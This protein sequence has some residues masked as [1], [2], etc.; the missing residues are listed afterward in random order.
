MNKL[1]SLCQTTN[2]L[3]TR[4]YLKKGRYSNDDGSTGYSGYNK[5]RGEGQLE[6][7][8]LD[9]YEITGFYYAET[10][11]TKSKV[12]Y[13]TFA[14]EPPWS[15]VIATRLDNN[16]TSTAT[17]GSKNT[18]SFTFDVTFFI[19]GCYDEDSYEVLLEPVV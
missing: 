7:K 16:S 9:G 5:A 4:F 6:P 18:S 10:F 3:K 11:S 19:G 1:L 17:K 2:S 8:Y 15:K 14:T 13:L 12:T